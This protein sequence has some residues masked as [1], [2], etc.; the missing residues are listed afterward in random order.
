M[1]LLKD[2]G[3]AL[4][5]ILVVHGLSHISGF[6]L[7]HGVGILAVEN[8]NDLF[9]L[10]D[11]RVT[12]VK[13]LVGTRDLADYNVHLALAVEQTWLGLLLFHMLKAGG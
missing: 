11:E 9:V 3:G 4:L 8:V 5:A 12:G 1:A 7:L 13:G 10:V 6:G 2:F